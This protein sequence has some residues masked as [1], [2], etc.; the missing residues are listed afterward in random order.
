MGAGQ[1]TKRLRDFA[2]RFAS[3]PR[4]ILLNGPPGCGKSTIARMFADEHPLALN[5]D[6][7]LVRRQV[8]GWQDQPQES[9]LLARRLVLD[10]AVAHLVARHDVV[11]PQYLGRSEFIEQLEVT[12]SQVSA[13]FREVVLMST[14][15]EAIRR[16]EDRTRA[17]VEPGHVEAGLMASREG[18]PDAVGA[19]YDRMATMLAGRPGARF[20]TVV[21][22]DPVA[23]YQRV[24]LAIDA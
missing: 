2:S 5:L 20:V 10:R 7:D 23:T 14:R 22:G 24:V 13:E 12:A 3:V 8:L 16:F 9:G 1:P 18:G 19:M 4:L 17:A 21:D 11:V 6:V 15:A